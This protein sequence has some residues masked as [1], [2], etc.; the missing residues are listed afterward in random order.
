MANITTSMLICLAINLMLFMGQMA[1]NEVS[2]ANDLGTP[3]SLLNCKGTLFAEADEAGCQNVSNLNVNSVNASETLPS[4]VSSISPTTGN[5][6]T[7]SW[8]TIKSWFGSVTGIGYF[9]AFVSAV[10]NFLKSLGLPQAF[11]FGVGALWY[12]LNIFLIIIFLRGGND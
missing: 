4:T 2:A 8:A 1:I 5:V 9:T 3:Q 11:V 10:P 7:D 6:F 12:L